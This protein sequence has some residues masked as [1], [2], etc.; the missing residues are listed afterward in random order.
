MPFVVHTEK[1]N[2]IS[3]VAA[4]VNDE[5]H[6][7]QRRQKQQQRVTD[8]TGT[9]SSST[10]VPKKRALAPAWTA[11]SAAAEVE[12]GNKLDANLEDFS[13]SSMCCN[14]H[15]DA[16]SFESRWYEIKAL[17]QLA[18]PTMIIQLG[19]VIPGF[20]IASYI[21]RTLGDSWST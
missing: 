10:V 21:G 7:A 11:D 8:T 18:I 12:N 16:T 4:E 6:T 9:S 5:I 3:S 13:D 19:Q 15:K 20:T 2:L 14:P 17:F 1:L